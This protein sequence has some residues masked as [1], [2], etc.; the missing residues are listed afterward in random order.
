MTWEDASGARSV[1]E[2]FE[3]PFV[4][5]QLPTP[6]I[7]KLGMMIEALDARGALLPG[8]AALREV[9]VQDAEADTDDGAEQGSTD[10]VA[11]HPEPIDPAVGDDPGSSA[12]DVDSPQAGASDGDGGSDG[13]DM[14]SASG[15]AG[16]AA[17]SSG[18]ASGASQDAS[19]DSLPDSSSAPSSDTP[20]AAAAAPA[21]VALAAPVGF[22]LR[23][24]AEDDDASDGASASITGDTGIAVVDDP[25]NPDAADAEGNAYVDYGNG[26]AGGESLTFTF[27]VPEAG[28][29]DLV[30]RY[31][32][33]AGNRP[34]RLDVN[35][36]L[37]DRMF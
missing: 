10:P 5:E 18:P 15:A 34:L 13:A 11:S 27:D 23:I 2:K 29:Y 3:R 37:F 30:L 28:E 1:F 8:V 32:M 6:P 22:S 17:A 4:F 19:Q 21:I 31:A 26:V 12:Q 33:G 9:L 14:D 25:T 35:G 16:S 7:G 20:P 24:Q 36:E